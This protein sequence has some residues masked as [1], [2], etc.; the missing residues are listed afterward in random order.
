MVIKAVSWEK[1]DIDSNHLGCKREINTGL[2]QLAVVSRNLMSNTFLFNCLINNTEVKILFH[3]HYRC[4][5]KIVMLFSRLKKLYLI[6]NKRNIPIY[7]YFI[8]INCIV[9]ILF[10]D[11]SSN[12]TAHMK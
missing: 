8:F 6:R 7:T 5:N 12:K 4:T 11:F 9:F 10:S 2:P 1:D 3:L